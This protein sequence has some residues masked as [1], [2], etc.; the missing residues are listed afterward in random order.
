MDGADEVWVAAVEE[1]AIALRECGHG[2]RVGLGLGLVKWGCWWREHSRQDTVAL[3]ASRMRCKNRTNSAKQSGLFSSNH[4]VSI[5]ECLVFQGA[6]I[7]P[8]P[9]QANVFALQTHFIK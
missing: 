8:K 9:L 4:S 6:T 2:G 5:T 7:A 1:T 3:P